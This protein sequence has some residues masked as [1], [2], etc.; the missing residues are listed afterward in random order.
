[1]LGSKGGSADYKL[2]DEMQ[3]VYYMSK[4][5]FQGLARE[6]GESASQP[7]L[8]A[9]MMG[10]PPSVYDVPSGAGLMP[11]SQ[12]YN[13]IAPE[14]RQGLW[15]PWNDAANQMQSVMGI[16]GQ[17]GSPRSGIRSGAA[18]TALGELYSDA[19]QKV[20]M[21]AWNMMQPGQQALWQA[22]LGRNIADYDG[23]M[24]QYRQNYG[25]ELEAW[26]MPFNIL[27]Q[28]GLGAAGSG[29][30]EQ[31]GNPWAGGLSGAMMGGLGAY[32]MFGGGGNN[33]SAPSNP[34][35]PFQA[36]TPNIGGRPA[37]DQWQYGCTR[38]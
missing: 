13:N 19:G 29:Y 1:M 37:V 14:V 3:R 11:T 25:T 6:G 28:A 31:R 9:P 16:Q 38:S 36:G 22:N 30:I 18:Q 23:R 33:Y 10:A 35:L 5:M 20:G 7:N 2:P 17:L 32:N 34:Y 27:P 12:W 4:P 21:Q 8:G 15:E 24:G 26:R